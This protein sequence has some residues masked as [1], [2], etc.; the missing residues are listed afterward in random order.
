[1]FPLPFVLTGAS[2]REC[3][4]SVPGAK[5]EKVSAELKNFFTHSIDTVSE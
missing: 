5:V 2:G 3:F 1:M 4:I